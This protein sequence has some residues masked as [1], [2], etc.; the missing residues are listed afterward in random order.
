MGINKSNIVAIALIG[1]LALV[2]VFGS[3]LV[4]HGRG[5]ASVPTATVTPTPTGTPTVTPT[6]TPTSTWTAV[7]TNTPVATNTRVP[8]NTPLA[9]QT[10]LPTSTPGPDP[11]E[12]FY[13]GIDAMCRASNGMSFEM[14]GV[15]PWD[16]HGVV[17]G[18]R[19]DMDWYN[20]S[21]FHKTATPFPNRRPTPGSSAPGLRQQPSMQGD[22]A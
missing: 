14:F 18:G 9:T 6:A 19:D 15:V 20:D 21:D 10:P 4:G 1:I 8:T 3:Y 17:T 7:P 16:C 5:V 2:G 11:E 13:D 12:A 22:G